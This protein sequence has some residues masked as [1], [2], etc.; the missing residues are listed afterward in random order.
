MNSETRNPGCIARTAY[1]VAVIAA[2]LL[3]AGLVWFTRQYTQAPPVNANRAAER[4][5]ALEEIRAAESKG[6]QEVGW[7]NEDKGVVRLPIET[8]MTL[9]EREWR[10]PSAA[11]SNLLARVE[12]A[13]FVPP[14]P[15]EQPSQFE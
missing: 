11:R 9:V 14:P 5:R 6:L 8:A 7:I 15:P 10:N 4:A 3:A 13:S 12:K 2:F 1:A